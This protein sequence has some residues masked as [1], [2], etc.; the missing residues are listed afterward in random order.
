MPRKSRFLAGDLVSFLLPNG[1]YVLLRFSGPPI[2]DDNNIGMYDCP[3]HLLDWAGK[4]LPTMSEI[5]K[6]PWKY[7]KERLENM[8]NHPH[9][10]TFFFSIDP[11]EKLDCMKL[12]A[13]MFPRPKHML[14]GIQ[15]GTH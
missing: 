1:K 7:T 2:D 14:W 15:S 3:Y 8:S 5:K 10:E 4:K 9:A 6:L 12:V 11:K 13:R